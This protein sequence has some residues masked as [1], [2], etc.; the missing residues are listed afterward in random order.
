MMFEM[1]E[2]DLYFS[3]FVLDIDEINFKFWWWEEMILKCL[4][5]YLILGIVFV[6]LF[7]IIVCGV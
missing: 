7:V 1:I 5:V 2:E 4:L 6:V 3:S